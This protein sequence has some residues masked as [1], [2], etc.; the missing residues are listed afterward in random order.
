[1]S[2]VSANLILFTIP[3]GLHVFLSKTN[4]L[5]KL[6]EG[7]NKARVSGSPPAHKY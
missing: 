6:I 3:L 5:E 1:M 2:C 4:Q 7:V